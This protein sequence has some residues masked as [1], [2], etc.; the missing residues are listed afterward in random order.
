MKLIPFPQHPVNRMLL[1][2]SVIV[3]SIAIFSIASWDVLQFH[4]ARPRTLHFHG[5]SL[6]DYANAP[7]IQDRYSK[8]KVSYRCLWL[9]YWW[10]PPIVEQQF[11]CW[12]RMLILLKL[13]S[14]LVSHLSQLALTSLRLLLSLRWL[15]QTGR[16]S[17]SDIHSLRLLV[18]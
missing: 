2:S 16:G 18:T 15:S 13:S 5:L 17:L 4:E 7:Q 11:S 8:T 14:L 12:F 9:A 1:H 10:V 6:Q 3:M